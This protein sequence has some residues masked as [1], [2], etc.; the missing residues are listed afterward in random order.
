VLLILSSAIA[1]EV[2][3]D[4]KRGFD[5]MDAIFIDVDLDGKPDRIQP[6]TYKT[7]HRPPGKHL[8]S[9]HIKNWITF[10]ITTSGGKTLKSIFTYNYGTAENGGSWVYALRSI[11]DENKDGRPDLMFY[12]GDDTSDETVILLNNGNRFPVHSRK[13]SD[14]DDW[15]REAGIGSK[16]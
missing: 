3:D 12:T 4:D 13:V 9:K 5:E 11:E 7:Y 8:L 14:S 16:P 10:H 2:S 6:R 1:Q 15:G